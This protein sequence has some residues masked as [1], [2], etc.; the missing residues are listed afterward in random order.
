MYI[1]II[2]FLVSCSLIA[3]SNKISNKFFKKIIEIIAVLIPCILAGLRALSVGTDV[4]VYVEPLFNLASKSDSFLDYLKMSWYR[5]WTYKYVA[6][7]ELLFNI[8]VYII[9]KLTH[10]IQW[11]LFTIQILI[12][13]PIYYGIKKFKQLKNK[14]WLAML[15]FYLLFYNISYNAMRQFI[16]IAILFWG[17]SCLINEKKGD[18]KFF[19]SLILGYFFHKSALLGIVIFVIYKILKKKS[20][21]NLTLTLGNH[22]IL[23][24]KI[25]LLLIIF[26]SIIFIFNSSILTNI[27][28]LIGLNYYVGYINGNVYFS[29]GKLIKYVPIILIIIFE[30]KQLIK[31]E[32]S[33]FYILMF[34][35]DILISYFSTVNIYAVRISYFFQIFNII[36]F[37]ILIGTTKYQLNKIINYVII[38]LYLGTYWYYNFV[39]TGANETIPYLL[40]K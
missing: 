3:L 33:Y 16:S 35:L 20:K 9:T 17:T 15:C 1:Y 18:K 7:F 38:L 36:L 32:N 25:A 5:V 26:L 23:V 6:D 10:N 11:I 12:I 22:K 29:I 31:N 34:I 39:I 30:Y 37:P 21:T 4:Q 40:F 19:L 14:E 13:F 28:E 8:M 27:L 24:R 2:I